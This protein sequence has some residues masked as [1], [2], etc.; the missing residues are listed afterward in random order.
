MP[1][2]TKYN[3]VHI[4]QTSSFATSEKSINHFV[5]SETDEPKGE[6]KRIQR[7]DGP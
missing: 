6:E 7:C 5:T 1:N 2:A 3:L 4:Y